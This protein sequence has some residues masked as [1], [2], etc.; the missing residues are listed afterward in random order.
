[1]AV[2]LFVP[3]VDTWLLVREQ[4]LARPQPSGGLALPGWFKVAI[5]AQGGLMVGW[6]AALFLG[7]WVVAPAWA[8]P[9][10]SVAYGLLQRSSGRRA[11]PVYR[12]TGSSRSGY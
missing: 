12:G 2:Y 4:R 11:C 10:T 3:T 6:G 5:G 9:L 1:L 7:P 8:W